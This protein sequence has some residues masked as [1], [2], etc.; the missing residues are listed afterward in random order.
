MND[1]DE[2]LV[3]TKENG[4]RLYYKNKKLHRET[5][6][7]IIV[8]EDI[9]KY[10][11]LPDANLYIPTNTPVEVK[12]T[13]KNKTKS[14][15]MYDMKNLKD[16][17]FSNPNVYSIEDP[18]EYKFLII[19]ISSYWLEGKKYTKEE[20]NSIMLKKEL[21]QELS[22]VEHQSKKTKI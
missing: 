11:N 14:T 6:P 8:K 10:L 19:P 15:T 13:N 4:D 1:K 9:N 20:F 22:I 7:A 16:I 21:D 18:I 3:Y 2:Y 17:L 12:D 5:G